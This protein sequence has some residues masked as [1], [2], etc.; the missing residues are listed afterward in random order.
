MKTIEKTVYTFAELSES[1]K[2]SACD[3]Y[4]QSLPCDWYADVCDDFE[5]C[6]SFM[7]LSDVQT[8]FSGFWSQGDGASFSARYAYRKNGLVDLIAYAPADTA[9]HEIA[10][11]IVAVQRRAFYRIDGAVTLSGHYCHEYTMH[12]ENDELLDC[13]RR[14]ARWLYATLEKEY[15]YQTSTEY[16]AEM[17]EANDWYF[18]EKGN[19]HA[20]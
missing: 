15:E 13:F 20:G 12:F 3:W 11:D 17:S 4:A 10:R 16:V 1:A 7:G 2:Q 18:D 5:M 14:L 8:R 9:L 19:F 6:V